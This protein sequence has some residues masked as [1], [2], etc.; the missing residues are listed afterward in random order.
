M[1]SEDGAEVKIDAPLPDTQAVRDLAILMRA[2][3]P[4]Y[5]GLSVEFQSIGEHRSGGQRVITEARLDRA[6]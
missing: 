5:S 2:E 6:P 4:V 3:P 1:V